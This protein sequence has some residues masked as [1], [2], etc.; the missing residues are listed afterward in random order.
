MAFDSDDSEEDEE[1][2]SPVLG[3]APSTDATMRLQVEDMS[4]EEASSG[5]LV[6]LPKL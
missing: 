1:N 6:V 4:V 2:T 5:K 3:Q